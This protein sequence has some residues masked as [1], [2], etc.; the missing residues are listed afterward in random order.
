M[1][2]KD[3]DPILSRRDEA[4]AKPGSILAGEFARLSHNAGWALYHAVR[5]GASQTALEK[6]YS[7]FSDACA[8]YEARGEDFPHAKALNGLS[9]LSGLL[10]RGAQSNDISRRCL[11]LLDQSEPS[12]AKDKEDRLFIIMKSLRSLSEN[13]ATPEECIRSAVRGREILDLLPMRTKRPDEYV[14]HRALFDRALGSAYARSQ[15]RTAVSLRL[16]EDHFTKA[17]A[18]FEKM[19][20]AK[21]ANDSAKSKGKTYRELSRS[22][23]ALAALLKPTDANS[24]ARILK[25]ALQAAEK[26]M[27][28]YASASDDSHWNHYQHSKILRDMGRTAEAL[29]A[30]MKGVAAIE[31][32]RQ[33]YAEEGNRIEWMAEKLPIYDQAIYLANELGQAELGFQLS[34]SCKA[35]TFLEKLQGRGL[36]L[37]GGPSKTS[38]ELTAHLGD[39][40]ALIEYH[41]GQHALSIFL[42][43]REGLKTARVI[44]GRAQVEEMVDNFLSLI[45]KGATENNGFF[46]RE[47]LKD[48]AEV[49]ILPVFGSLESVRRLY[50]V[51]SGL[52]SYLPFGTLPLP[53]GGLAIEKWEL[54]DLPNAALLIP[55]AAPRPAT[56]DRK[57]LVLANPGMNLPN[58]EEEASEV[59]QTF[60][61]A[62]VALREKATVQTLDKLKGISHVHIAC[63]GHYEDGDKR[64]SRLIL[65]A[66]MLND[67]VLGVREIVAL[68]L[69]GVDLAFLSCCKSA[70]GRQRAGDEFEG[71]HRAFLSAGARSVVATL[72]DIHDAVTRQLVVSFYK[73]LN[74]GQP[75]SAALRRAKLEVLAKHPHPYYWAGFKLIGAA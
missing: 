15:P 53:K 67:G 50:I 58:A 54:L 2:D 68:P 66:N 29:T 40:E 59:A 43:T 57:I 56:A 1:K 5:G 69:G 48:L 22:R 18:F 6:S 4:F 60:P 46:L 38:A 9:L 42:L 61:A 33:V 3:A 36:P 45:Q 75:K 26:A 21:S 17:I 65:A 27:D 34:Q 39:G 74:A 63:H 20:E 23:R 11:E 44:R 7:F 24:A 25:A 14:R 64:G 13:S 10:G 55:G 71:V 41:L 73:H 16:S 70:R 28:L 30:C 47:A 52:L 51:P 62:V 32:G 72:W 49:L 35:R 8:L 37:V 19:K 12:T 31:S